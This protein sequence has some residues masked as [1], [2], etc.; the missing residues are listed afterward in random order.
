ME[1]R[2]L[3]RKPAF[4]LPLRK[5]PHPATSEGAR[6]RCLVSP[7]CTET[8]LQ[9]GFFQFSKEAAPQG[10]HM[11]GSHSLTATK[12]GQRLSLHCGVEG[13]KEGGE[14]TDKKEERKKEE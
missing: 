9:L 8:F 5:M 2:A 6:R 11:S 7:L 12:Q 3:E 10:P 1:R 4:S 14:K 13:R